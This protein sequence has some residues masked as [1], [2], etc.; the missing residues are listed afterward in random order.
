MFWNEKLSTG[1]SLGDADLST[2]WGFFF[3][4]G[5]VDGPRTSTGLEGAVVWGLGEEVWED[6]SVLMRRMAACCTGAGSLAPL[7]ASRRCALIEE[8][9]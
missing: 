1:G 2:G 6:P 7:L 5:L 3:I 4:L 9:V 8:A